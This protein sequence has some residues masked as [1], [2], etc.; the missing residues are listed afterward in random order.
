MINNWEFISSFDLLPFEVNTYQRIEILRQLIS[1]LDFGQTSI[2]SHIANPINYELLLNSFTDEQKYLLNE[3]STDVMIRLYM[4]CCE[5]GMFD[6]DSS[7]GN[8]YF[9]YFPEH[10]TH[11]TIVFMKSDPY[12]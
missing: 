7:S 3:L 11:G 12:T 2:E 9:P 6:T 10:I 8:K 4:K 5:Y 1:H